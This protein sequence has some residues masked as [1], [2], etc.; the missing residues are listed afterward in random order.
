MFDFLLNTL[1]P[2]QTDDEMIQIFISSIISI[3]S[4]DEQYLLLK[5]WVV[6]GKP[7]Y[8]KDKAKV[9]I[10]AKLTVSQKHS[11]FKKL[12]ISI[13][14]HTPDNMMFISEQLRADTEN[15]DLN[16][17]CILACEAATYDKEAKNKLFD[18][19]MSEKTNYSIWEARAIMST[20]MPK[21]QF[22]I[23]EPLID[24][25]FA[26][27]QGVFKAKL[28]D[29]RDAIYA[30][31]SPIKFASSEILSKYEMLI[32]SLDEN[33]NKS[34]LKNLKEDVLDIEKIL[35]GKELYAKSFHSK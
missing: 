3:S 6:D 34:L 14:L 31:L 11:I 27:I 28:R 2:A 17:R 1:L 25:F 32:D 18:D 26:Q 22:D 20:L 13:K 7:F 12:A 24:K 5:E 23:V 19:V 9:H 15:K 35:R 8:F 21:S 30:G 29:E 4:T 33:E 16:E 10:E